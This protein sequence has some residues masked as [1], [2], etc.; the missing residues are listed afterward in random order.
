LLE[1]KTAVIDGRRVAYRVSGGPGLPV[2]VIIG[3]GGLIDHYFPL[4]GELERL[5]HPMFLPDLP[6]FGESGPPVPRHPAE[7]AAW[8]D[9]V[10]RGIVGQPYLLVS[11]SLGAR[12]AAEYLAGEAPGCRGTVFVLP[13]LLSDRCQTVFWRGV[14]H[15]LWPVGP[16]VFEEMRWVRNGA[17]WRGAMSLALPVRAGPQVPCLVLWGRRDA[18]RWLFP[19]WRKLGGEVRRYDWDHSPQLRDTAAL[20]GVIHEFASR[21]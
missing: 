7:W 5:G 18:G 11:H 15:L 8:V 20:A 14:A 13:W 21:L 17:L 4:A 12:P 16:H 6:G 2:L 10:A 19:G 3:W 9:G 1:K